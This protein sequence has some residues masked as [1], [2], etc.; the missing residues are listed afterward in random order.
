[1]EGEEQVF[2]HPLRTRFHG[3]LPPCVEQKTVGFRICSQILPYHKQKSQSSFAGE[4][5]EIVLLWVTYSYQH[6]Q[7]SS[8]R[9]KYYVMSWILKNVSLLFFQKLHFYLVII[10]QLLYSFKTIS[11]FGIIWSDQLPFKFSFVPSKRTKR[12]FVCNQEEYSCVEYGTFLE[13]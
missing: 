6:L 7:G 9:T 3:E 10:D 8:G 5:N 11:S 12:I 1:M 4:K 2:L 13:I